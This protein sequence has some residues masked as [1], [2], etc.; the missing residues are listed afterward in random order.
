[1][2]IILDVGSLDRWY[3]YGTAQVDY[4]TGE[5]YIVATFL[6]TEVAI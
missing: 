2:V 4:Q 5:Q 1:M 6:N 3:K